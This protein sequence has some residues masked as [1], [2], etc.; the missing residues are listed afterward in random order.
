MVS[1]SLEIAA[2]TGLSAAAVCGTFAHAI[3]NARC[4]WCGPLLSRGT[5][6]APPRVALT[7]DDG[8]WP[9]TTDRVLDMLGELNVKAAFFVIGRYVERHPELVRRIDREGHLIGNHTY[10]HLGL[11]FLRGAAFWRS[12]LDRTDTAIE[13]ATGL[14]P[15]LYRPPLGM[16]TPISSRAVRH[17]HTTVTWTRSAKDGLSTTSDRILARLLPR[18][19]AGDILLLHDGVSPQSRRDPSVTTNALPTLIRGLRNRG[20]EPVRLDQ[21]T[22]LTPYATS[23]AMTH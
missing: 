4:Q 23:K 1:T 8:P 15:R 21:L 13:R 7:F 22:G 6:E 11:S 16:K 17:S 19:R 3:F 18:S 5:R 20:L 2:A 12:Q 10:D 14:R 9:G